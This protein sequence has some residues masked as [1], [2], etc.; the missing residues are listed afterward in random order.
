DVTRH[1][2]RVRA[3]ATSPR[4]AVSGDLPGIAGT[5]RATGGRAAYVVWH[6]AAAGR[7]PA[8]DQRRHALRHAVVV[9]AR[10]SAPPRGRTAVARALSARHRIA[11]T[12]R[13]SLT[14]T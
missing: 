4:G 13:R 3:H 6:G 10:R 7:S 12:L 8:E 5:L 11:R 2:C 1:E 14:G 9:A